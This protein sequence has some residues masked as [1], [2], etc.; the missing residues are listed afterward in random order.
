MD[1]VEKVGEGERVMLKEGKGRLNKEEMIWEK[2]GRGG[3]R[4]KRRRKVKY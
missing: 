2:E 3:N 4:L 1:I